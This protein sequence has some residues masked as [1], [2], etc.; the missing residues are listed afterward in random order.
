VIDLAKSFEIDNVSTLKKQELIFKI[1][2][3]Q[4]ELNGN[5]YGEGVLEISSEGFGFL[6]QPEYSYTPGSYGHLCFPFTD[7]KVWT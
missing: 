5:I 4:S 3:K 2:E 1:L 6:R 7:K